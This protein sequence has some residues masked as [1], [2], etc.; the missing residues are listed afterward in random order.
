MTE[1]KDFFNKRFRLILFIVVAFVV[2]VFFIAQNINTFGNILLTM[3]GFGSV[4]LVHEFGH[5]VVAKLSDIKV[6]AFSIFMPPT[7]FGVQRIENGFKFRILPK[8]FAK[9]GDETGEGASYSVWWF[10]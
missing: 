6:E 5:F 10:C 3:F 9:E 7:L 1:L 4:V 8:L 2:V